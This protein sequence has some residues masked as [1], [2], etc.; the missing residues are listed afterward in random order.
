ML[1]LR[2][3]NAGKCIESSSV[4]SHDGIICNFSS[5]SSI[6]PS[7]AGICLRAFIAGLSQNIVLCAVGRIVS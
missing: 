7:I 6:Y 4:S 1:Q 3:E 5:L 2:S